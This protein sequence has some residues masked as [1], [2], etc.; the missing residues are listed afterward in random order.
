MLAPFARK[1]FGF[2]FTVNRRESLIHFLFLH[3]FG[4]PKRRVVT[5][6]NYKYENISGMSV[7]VSVVL[8]CKV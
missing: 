1:T 5:N 6:Y 4:G 8:W 2:R 3:H 7:H